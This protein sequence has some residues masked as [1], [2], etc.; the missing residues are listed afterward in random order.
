MHSLKVSLKKG[1]KNGYYNKKNYMKYE[2]IFGIL[3]LVVSCSAI[4]L[5]ENWKNPDIDVYAPSK[6][7]IVGLTSNTKARQQFE[8]QL[9]AEYESRGVEAVMS[10][11]LFEA[12]FATEKKTED[13]LKSLENKL[14]VDGFDTVLFTK[15]IGV[16]DKIAYK[17]DYDEHDNTHRK[18]REDYLKYQDAF[19]NPEYYNEYTVYHAE[20]AM[21]CICPTKERELIWKGYID[22]V[23]PESESIKEIVRDYVR[24][25]IVVLE[26]Q[27]LIN[28]KLLEDDINR[29]A[30]IN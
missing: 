14:I 22:I 6:V 5:V 20:T 13:D 19:Y 18:F 27:Q 11:D 28:P 25:V 7:L 26:E 17:K 1:N 29:D 30:I 9:K 10:L 2:K 15:V 16:E 3:I 4:Q 23:D 12:S 8:N 21:Y 24:L